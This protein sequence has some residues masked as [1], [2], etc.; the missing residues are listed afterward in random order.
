MYFVVNG[1]NA[2]EHLVSDRVVLS[3]QKV[4]LVKN[5]VVHSLWVFSGLPSR[6]RAAIFPHEV[7]IHIYVY[8]LYAYVQGDMHIN[9]NSMLYA[10]STCG[11]S[12]HGMYCHVGMMVLVLHHY[13]GASYDA[14]MHQR[15]LCMRAVAAQKHIV[16]ICVLFYLHIIF[17]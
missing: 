12:P 11:C 13:P 16:G 9:C 7:Y 14:S 17:D 4:V 15:S 1:L 2:A 5:I 6:L 8:S 3:L 10:I